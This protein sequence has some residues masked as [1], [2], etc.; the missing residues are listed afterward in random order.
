MRPKLFQPDLRAFVGVAIGYAVRRVERCTDTSDATAAS[1][2]LKG[3]GES[4]R[5][6]AAQLPVE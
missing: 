6:I 5:A 4:F 2:R 1:A 3:R